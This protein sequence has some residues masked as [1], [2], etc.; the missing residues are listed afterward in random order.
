MR[1]RA[2]FLVVFILVSAIHLSAYSQVFLGLD[3]GGRNKRL[4]FYV[5]DVITFKTE[6]S[7]KFIR[8]KI[9][10]IGDSVIISGNSYFLS[11]FHKVRVY[12]SEGMNSLLKSG[13]GQLPLAAVWF[14]FCEAVSTELHHDYP[15]VE[16]K[17]LKLSA[18]L[19]VASIIMY[20]LS[21]RT[22]TIGYRHPFRVFGLS[23]K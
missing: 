21:Y 20:K 7:K 3:K 14:L 8:G 10:S 23:I 17:H 19:I 18:G 13:V 9:E 6:K 4:R 12:R 16:A 11:D 15:L 1:S 22:Y 2:L 5:G